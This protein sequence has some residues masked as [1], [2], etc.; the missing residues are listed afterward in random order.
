MKF[1]FFSSNLIKILSIFQ[2]SAF[3]GDGCSKDSKDKTE[4]L[5]KN[6]RFSGFH[7]LSVVMDPPT[8]FHN[9]GGF[10]EESLPKW[11]WWALKRAPHLPLWCRRRERYVPTPNISTPTSLGLCWYF[12]SA[13]MKNW[14]KLNKEF[15]LNPRCCASSRWRCLK[16]VL[17]LEKMSIGRSCPKR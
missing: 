7:K 16:E 11:W 5:K 12:R 9:F 3:L 14:L 15:K 10:F 2:R 1:A 17:R 13:M 6:V 8:K 4:I